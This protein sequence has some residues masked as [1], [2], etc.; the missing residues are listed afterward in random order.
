MVQVILIFLIFAFIHSIT[1][2]RWFKHL[3]KQALGDA[4]MRVWYRALYNAVSFFNVLIALHFIAQVPDHQ[5]WTAPLWLLLVMHLIQIAG[6]GSGALAFEYLDGAEFMGFKQV[7]RYL[8]RR[9]VAGNI[10]GLTQKELVTS[11]VYGVI[12]HPMYLAGIVIF[13]FNPHIT[14]NRL[15]ITILADLYFIFGMFIEERRFLRIFGDQYREYMKRVPGM[16]PRFGRRRE[17]ISK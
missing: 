7:W 17:R 13:T 6:I 14:V 1:V 11:G 15:T 4:F 16:I 9:E 5:L 2:T 3:C 12:R 10:E 8:T